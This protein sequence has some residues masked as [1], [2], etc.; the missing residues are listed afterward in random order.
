MMK[1]MMK[2]LPPAHISSRDESDIMLTAT[3]MFPVDDVPRKRG[4]A[5]T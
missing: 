4:L 3:E 1:T 5:S 2:Q